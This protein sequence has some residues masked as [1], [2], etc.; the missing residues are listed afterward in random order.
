MRM[1]EFSKK[2]IGGEWEDLASEFPEF[3]YDLSPEVEEWYESLKKNPS[4]EVE[5]EDLCNLRY[6]FECNIGWKEIIRE[7]FKSIRNLLKEA[8]D[9]GDEVFYKTFIF[10]EKFGE[11]RDQGDFY[12]KDS[13]KYR[14]MYYALQDILVK[15][16]ANVCEVCGE[17][18]VLMVKRGGFGWIKTLCPKHSEEL[19][20]VSKLY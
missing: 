11:L 3:I 8:H 18:G 10:K 2:N 6:G 14:T 13:I 17:E 15:K 19:E 4:I 16:S 1:M 5:K 9:N 12:G 7:Y 20:Y